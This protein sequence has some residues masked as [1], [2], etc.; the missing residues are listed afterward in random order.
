MGFLG[1]KKVWKIGPRLS[2]DVSYEKDSHMSSVIY[3]L[4]HFFQ[5]ELFVQRNIE[6]QKQRKMYRKIS[7]M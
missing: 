1:E 5:Q 3:L 4:A 2:F 7:N 6:V